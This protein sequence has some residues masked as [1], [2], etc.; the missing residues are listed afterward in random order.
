ME[1]FKDL[2]GLLGI[3][4]AIDVAQIHIQK[5]RVQASIEKYY[6]YKSKAYNMQV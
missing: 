2:S 6:S 1:G 4:A 5:P 3:Q